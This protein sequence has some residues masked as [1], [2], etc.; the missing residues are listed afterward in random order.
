MVS[1]KDGYNGPICSIDHIK[2]NIEGELSLLSAMAS[3]F[4]YEETVYRRYTRCQKLTFQ[5][6]NE[7]VMPFL[8]RNENNVISQK[9]SQ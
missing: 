1:R 2:K 4:F 8:D 3:T 5:K 6:S 7:T 9:F